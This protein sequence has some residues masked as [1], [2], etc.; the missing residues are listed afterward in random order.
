MDILPEYNIRNLDRLDP[1]KLS[2]KCCA[3]ALEYLIRTSIIV[4]AMHV[5]VLRQFT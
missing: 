2:N 1:Q 3:H 5:H 4:K